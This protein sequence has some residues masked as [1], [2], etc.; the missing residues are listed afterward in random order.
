V[1][2][3]VKPLVL[4]LTVVAVSTSAPELA[5]GLTASL[6]GS[7]ALA[8]GNIAGTNVFNRLFILGLSALLCPLPLHVQVL[9]RE[10]PVIIL[11]AALMIGLAWDGVLTRLDGGVLFGAAC[12][13]HRSAHPQEPGRG[14]SDQ[15]RVQDNV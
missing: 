9:K 14:A 11:S 5:V 10:L 12:P 8:V 15:G 3:G 13:L 7:G 1:S 2:L 6:L 4:G